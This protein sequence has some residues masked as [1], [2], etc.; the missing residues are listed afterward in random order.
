MDA[1]LCGGYSDGD[2]YLIHMYLY[3]SLCLKYLTA[4]KHIPLHNLSNQW[5]IKTKLSL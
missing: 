5:S 1:V 4:N 2:I 3:M